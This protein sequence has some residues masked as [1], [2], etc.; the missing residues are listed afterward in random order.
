MLQEISIRNFAII[1]DL[2]ICFESGLTVLSGET[3]AGKSI[4]INAVNLLLGSRASAALI[5]TG[6]ESAELEALFRIGPDSSTART[7]RELGYDP[8]EGLLIRRI[9]SSSDRHRIYINGRLA[10]MQ[11]L[12]AIT[13]DLASISGQHAH[14]GLLR[15]D[16]HL[17]ILDQY[18]G[19]LDLRQAYQSIYRGILPLI[20]KEQE[21]LHRQARQGEQLELLRFQ[22]QEIAAAQVQP[23]EDAQLEK[24]RLRL[25]NS[26]NLYQTV[27]QCVDELYNNDGAVV[28]RL[29]YFSKELA[30]A[31]AIDDRL[32]GRADAI[33]TLAY[34][35][36]DLAANLRD[37]LNRI[38]MDPRQLEEVEVRLDTLNKLKRK[39]GGS[40]ERVLAHGQAADRQLEEI[41]N[42]DAAIDTVR[43]ELKARH[44]QL[45]RKA[46]ALSQKRKAAATQLAAAVERELASLKMAGTRFA[47][48]LQPLPAGGAHDAYLSHNGGGLGESGPDRIAFMMAPNVGEAIKPLAAIA[49]GGELSRVVLALKAILA[50]NESLETIVF[51]EVDAGIGGSVAER[52]GKKLAGLSRRHQVLCITHLPQI[53]KYAD[54][55]YRIVKAVAKGRTQTTITPLK[56]EDRVE[57]LAR[58]L[59]G[60]KIT[61]ATRAHAEEMLNSATAKG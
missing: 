35:V 34:G 15:E 23:D 58:M 48:Q 39:Y 40:L 16:E 55:H 28:E 60:E 12:T 52:V 5:R 61:A 59:G 29:G 47:V 41:G 7:M 17:S 22:S 25:R 49:S 13:A 3:G 20:Q 4:I 10:T 1:Q 45:V 51:D 50:R 21:L 32:Q 42:L 6:A 24:E 57:E 30:R 19:L 43:Q 54:Q 9:I 36:E 27:R 18:G 8:R 44:A 11:V 56:T 53:A 37:Y 46:E 38:D 14:Q 31:A 26:E 2:T 33:D